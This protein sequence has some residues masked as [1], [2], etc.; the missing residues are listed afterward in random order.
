[1]PSRSLD[2]T[3]AGTHSRSSVRGTCDSFDRR[4]ERFLATS[5]SPLTWRSPSSPW[6]SLGSVSHDPYST[7]LEG[8]EVRT[9]AEHGFPRDS[10]QYRFRTV[11]DIL[12]SRNG[13]PVAHEVFPGSTAGVG[14]FRAALAHVKARVNTDRAIMVGNR[15]MVSK[16]ALQAVYGLGLGDF[17]EVWMRRPRTMRKALGRSGRYRNVKDNF[18]V[19]G[20]S[21]GESVRRVP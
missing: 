7:Y 6:S 10:R 20:P 12:M 1:M 21:M 15:G 8:D 5:G 13:T 9:F 16:G 3:G 14:A 2:D 17:G 11:G 4:P 19:G 18:L